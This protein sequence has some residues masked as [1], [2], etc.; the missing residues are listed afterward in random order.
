MVKIGNAVYRRNRHFLKPHDVNASP[1]VRQPAQAP[2]RSVISPQPE[3]QATIN[4]PPI[5]Q[6]AKYQ[7][8]SLPPFSKQRKALKSQSQ[9]FR[10]YLHSKSTDPLT[11][12]PQSTLS[13]PKQSQPY[14]G[15][16]PRSSIPL[17]KFTTPVQDPGPDFPP[18]PISKT[19]VRPGPVSPTTLG[20][21]RDR[22][23]RL[24]KQPVR[25]QD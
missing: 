9:A 20:P 22:P 18:L 3:S 21:Q 5:C 23:K 14:V 16:S 17:A 11:T 10:E 25:F 19:S 8:S 4:Q 1:P 24:I 15:L 13:T 7:A 2:A 6:P 12:L